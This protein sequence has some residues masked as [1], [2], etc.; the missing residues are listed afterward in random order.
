MRYSFSFKKLVLIEGVCF[1][2]HT[3]C[4]FNTS[5]C[6]QEKVG[7]KKRKAVVFGEKVVCFLLKVGKVCPKNGGLLQCGGVRCARGV[8]VLA[9]ACR[10][11]P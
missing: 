1:F 4:L 5:R 8:G 10:R 3:W 6:V 9:D 11:R 7:R 2:G